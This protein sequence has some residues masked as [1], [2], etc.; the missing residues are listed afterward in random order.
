MTVT[1]CNGGG[2]TSQPISRTAVPAPTVA[3]V[4]PTANGTAT[5]TPTI[6]G[7][8]TPNAVVTISGGPGSTGGP[9]SVTASSTG[10]WSTSALTLPSGP[11]TV[12]VVAS[13]A[14][15][16]SQPVV[17]NFIA[18]GNP[19]YSL[20]VKVL[21]Q[22][23]LFNVSSGTLMRD[24]LRAGGYLPLTSPYSASV[25]SR[26]AQF[27]GGGGET[28]T[29]AVLLANAGTP[30]AIVDWVLVELRDAAN[31]ATVVATRSGLVQRDGDVVLPMDGATPLIFTG[32][33][34]S[35]YFVAVKHRN[36]LGAMTA[37]ALPLSTTGTVADFTTMTDAQV[38]DKPGT[39]SYNGV[40][41][42]TVNGKR[43][44][45]AG[46]ANA[47]GKAKYIGSASDNTP[48]LNEVVTAQ[49]A[50]PNPA[51]NYDFATGYY[52]GDVDMNGKSKYQGSTNDPT[53]IFSNVVVAYPLN[54]L[55]LYNYDFLIE[56]LP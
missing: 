4:T 40:E 19:G 18:V 3:I 7:T 46:D 54:V 56:Q 52:Y 20:N 37:A 41:M 49:G 51:Y 44:L 55:Q 9:I 33:T 34:S 39:T 13:N 36:H 24:D 16:V 22:G 12:T 53:W 29:Q 2:C 31:P 32:L 42:V 30:N 21:L 25:T 28:T 50:N 1:A 35:S 15:G 23:A 6:S 5:T 26:F 8:A 17:S 48:I 38:Y 45:W 11:A 47:D 27:G 14:G 10:Q 43:A